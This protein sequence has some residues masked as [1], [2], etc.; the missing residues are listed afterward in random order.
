MMGRLGELLRDSNA[1]AAAEMALVLPLLLVIMM[2]SVEG[3]NYFLAEHAVIK[4]VR[5]GARYASRIPIEANYSCTPP[6]ATNDAETE[7]RNITRT[8]TIDGSGQLRRPYSDEEVTC[9]GLAQTVVVSVRCADKDTYP[10]MWR[11]M[12]TDIPIVKVESAVKY[13]PVLSGIAL[14]GTLCIRAESEIPVIG[15]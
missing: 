15:L 2:G 5:D 7:I 13:N 6:Q 4:Q 14:S 10:G 12:G 1:S 3:G 8:G 11:A 9:G